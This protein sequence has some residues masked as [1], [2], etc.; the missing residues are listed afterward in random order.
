MNTDL[1]LLC[2]FL[3]ES[4]KKRIQDTMTDLIIENLT[5][6]INHEW[7][8]PPAVLEDM[9]DSIVNDAINELMEEYKAG[10]KKMIEAK[11]KEM[12]ENNVTC[13]IN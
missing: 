1:N 8:M 10:M 12:F 9:F 4:N 2:E 6:A 3:G 11:M 5:E 13:I 7:I